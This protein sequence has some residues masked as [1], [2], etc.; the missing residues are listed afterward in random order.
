MMSSISR[1]RQ[2]NRGGV[3]SFKRLKPEAKVYLTR[4]I[5]K[6]WERYRMKKLY[7]ILKGFTTWKTIVKC[8]GAKQLLPDNARAAS[9]LLSRLHTH[10]LKKKYFQKLYRYYSNRNEGRNTIL[11]D[12]FSCKKSLDKTF[13]T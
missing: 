4:T 9:R 3:Q 8:T 13:F 6:I 12:F 11:I 1:S 5:S 10:K 7:R 2:R